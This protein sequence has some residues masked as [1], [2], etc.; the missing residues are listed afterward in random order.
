M[1]VSKQASQEFVTTLSESSIA[2]SEEEARGHIVALRARL[3]EIAKHNDY[4]AQ[5]R[6]E[7]RVTCVHI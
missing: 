3:S 4:D 6:A 7:D 5:V 1:V 2:V